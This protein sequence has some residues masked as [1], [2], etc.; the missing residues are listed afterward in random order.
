MNQ[1]QAGSL[2]NKDNNKKAQLFSKGVGSNPTGGG[3]FQVGNFFA[4]PEHRISSYLPHDTR[5]HAKWSSGKESSQ[6][7]ILEVLIEH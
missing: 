1:P 4:I 5:I 2:V 6:L 7:I 3:S